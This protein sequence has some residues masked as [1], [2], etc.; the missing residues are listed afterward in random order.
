MYKGKEIKNVTTEK[1]AFISRIADQRREQQ[2][3]Y[4]DHFLEDVA[5]D[6]TEKVGR[7]KEDIPGSYCYDYLITTV[8]FDITPSLLWIRALAPEKVFFICSPETL[9]LVDAIGRRTGL[10][11]TQVEY[12]AVEGADGKDVYERIKDYI[13]RHRLTGIDMPRAAIDITGGKKSMVTSASLAAN[14]LGI[15]ILYV[16]N[17]GH[18]PGEKEFVPGKESP[19]ILEDPLAVFGDRLSSMAVAKFNSEDF[20]SAAELFQ[21]VKERVNHPWK[22]EAFEALA[23]GCRAVEEMAFQEASDYLEQ[24]LVLAEKSGAEDFPFPEIRR[25]RAA[26]SPLCGLGDRTSREI[27]GTEEIYWHLFGYL[28]MMA[29]H[30]RHRGRHDIA[31]LLTYRCLEMFMQHRLLQY[32]ILAEK[33]DVSKITG[34]IMNKYNEQ[35]KD[36]FPAFTPLKKESFQYGISLMKGLLLLQAMEDRAVEGMDLK[37]LMNYVLLRNKSRLVHGFEVLP[38]E[39]VKAF[40]YIVGQLAGEEWKERE[41]KK[42]PSFQE[43]SRRFAFVNLAVP[44]YRLP[45]E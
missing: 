2:S 17:N 36:I 5:A 13:S 21:A 9:P 32:G 30:H 20:E 3:Y 18:Y 19:S 37:K 22:Y 23:K 39:K 8:G 43:F 6:F 4:E 34:E 14:H 24:A 33:P 10:S 11:F 25:Q 42:K 28:Y 15:D 40:Y 12:V 7:E 38:P 1:K 35:G 26:L 29:D 31:A 45:T 41:E 44:H 16:D 27:L